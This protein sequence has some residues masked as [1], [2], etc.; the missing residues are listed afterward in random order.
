MEWRYKFIISVSTALNKKPAGEVNATKSAE[1]KRNPFLPPEPDLF[2]E[3]ILG[4]H[5]LVLNKFNVVDHH[6]ILATKDFQHQS[7]PLNSKDFA[8]LWAVISSLNCL[9]FYNCGPLSGA[10][11]PHKHLQLLPLPMLPSSSYDCPVESLIFQTPTTQNK[12]FIIENMPFKHASVILDQRELNT[13]TDDILQQSG[14]YIAD[15][16]CNLLD[17][18]KKDGSLGEFSYNF[19][20]TKKWMLVVPRKEEKYGNISINSLGFSG[21]LLVRTAEDLQI[22]KSVGP[23]H[24][25]EQLTFNS[26]E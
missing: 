7:E 6:L 11:Q 1:I 18:L 25:L 8:A 14:K 15:T 9:G 12:P 16:Y 26:R 17:N 10:S 4:T 22:L 20:M 13:G 23:M 2:V 21:A 5:N 19:L 24:L 3:E